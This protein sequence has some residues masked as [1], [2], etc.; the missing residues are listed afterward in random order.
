[1]LVQYLHA[2]TFLHGAFDHILKSCRYL[3]KKIKNVMKGLRSCGCRYAGAGFP[4][5]LNH[6][7]N[8]TTDIM[9]MH[10][11]IYAVFYTKSLGSPSHTTFK[12]VYSILCTTRNGK[13]LI[14]SISN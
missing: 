6:Q 10:Q 12:Y 11:V 3:F 13:L 8:K 4:L 2:K 1:M 14:N 7:N 9:S 5:V